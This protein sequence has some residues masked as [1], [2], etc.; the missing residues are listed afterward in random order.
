[1]HW[2]SVNRIQK[3]VAV[4]DP[5]KFARTKLQQQNKIEDKNIFEGKHY[6]NLVKEK[7]I[8]NK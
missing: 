8:M 3:V 1:M 2:C 6:R 4:A 5:R 7:K